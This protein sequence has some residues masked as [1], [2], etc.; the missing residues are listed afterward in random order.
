MTISIV[1]IRPEHAAGLAE[2]QS[3]C[4]P[5]L[6]RH[7][8]MGVPHFLRHYEIF[9]DGEFVA[10]VD[11]EIV[12]LGSG[13][14]MDFDF[15]HP[16]HTFQEM[17]AGSYYTNHNPDGA[18]YYGADISVHPDYRGRGIGKL[19]Y[20]A[21]KELVMRTNRRGIVAG[22]VLPGYPQQR[23]RMKI[24]EYME[25]VVAG[26]LWDSTLSFQLKNGFVVRGML[27]DYIEDSASDNWA[28]LICWENPEY[29]SD[30]AL[31]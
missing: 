15:A 22:G 28:T 4:F 11:D 23:A 5:T 9:P 31:P 12:G 18:W 7:E 17:I 24:H 25:R 2:L 27:E 13:F 8:L 21:R 14:F 10:L 26:E 1:T 6:G 16:N 30:P 20:A 29:R 19:L 3:V